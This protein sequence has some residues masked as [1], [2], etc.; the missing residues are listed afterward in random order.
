MHG[1]SNTS[2]VATSE[3]H[4][5]AVK[6]LLSPLH[7]GPSSRKSGGSYG[8]ESLS[9]RYKSWPQVSPRYTSVADGGRE[10][11]PEKELCYAFRE[12]VPSRFGLCTAS[13]S[14][15]QGCA[16]PRKRGGG[17]LIWRTPQ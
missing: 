7:N 9:P 17:G 16:Y 8:P 10:W 11:V 1:H 15:R 14:L 2:L 6:T 13:T 4:A 5:S 3:Y 12:E